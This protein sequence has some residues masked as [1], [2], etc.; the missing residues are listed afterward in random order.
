[1]CPTRGRRRHRHAPHLNDATAH[2]HRIPGVVRRRLARRRRHLSE[3]EAAH[4]H[5]SVGR[6]LDD[7]DRAAAA[8]NDARGTLADD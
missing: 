1:M 3:R 4:A 6:R 2:H 7:D 8:P 5:L